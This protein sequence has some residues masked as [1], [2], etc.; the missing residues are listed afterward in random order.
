M[1]TGDHDGDILAVSQRWWDDIWRDGDIEAVDE[2]FSDPF[3]RHT[4]AGTET[5]TRAAFKARLSEIQRALSHPD[6]VIDDRVV[7]GDTV[8]TRATSSGLNRET[9]EPSIVTWLMIQRFEHE[10]VVEH[11]VATFPGVDWTG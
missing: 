5:E 8:W 3:V 10:R 7:Q 1:D 2:I 11:W 6:T 4:A 9:G